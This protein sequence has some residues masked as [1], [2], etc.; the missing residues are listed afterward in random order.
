MVRRRR[1]RGG[2][3][4]FHVAPDAHR[5]LGLT[6]GAGY[7]AAVKAL[8]ATILLLSL[9]GCSGPAPEVEF[10]AS[11]AFFTIADQRVVVPFVALSSVSPL[12]DGGAPGPD[13]ALTDARIKAIAGRPD[14]AAPA[15]A[16]TIT[17]REYQFYGEHAASL[18]IC[19]RLSRKWSQYMCR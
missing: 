11:D 1:R 18:A 9:A 3:A 5:L 15:A 8:A 17:I 2:H 12:P 19:P 6:S 4:I 10:L 13:V 7:K 16:V 14:A